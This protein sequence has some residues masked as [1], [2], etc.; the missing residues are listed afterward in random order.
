MAGSEGVLMATPLGGRRKDRK[1]LK[2]CSHGRVSH[3]SDQ[4]RDSIILQCDWC[5]A[6]VDIP[7]EALVEEGPRAFARYPLPSVILGLV[8]RH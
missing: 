5:K 6:K 4:R 1:R 3:R 2:R 8:G 7:R